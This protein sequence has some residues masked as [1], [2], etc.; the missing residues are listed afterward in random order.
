MKK[1]IIYDDD[2]EPFINSEDEC[3]NSESIQSGGETDDDND[4][5]DD[6]EHLDLDSDEEKGYDSEGDEEYDP[7]NDETLVDD[8]APKSDNENDDYDEEVD[9]DSENDNDNNDDDYIDNDEDNEPLSKTCHA[10]NLN[11]EFIT[12]DEDDSNMYAKIDFIQIKNEDRITDPQMTYYE[13]VRIL[14][15]RAQQINYG[16]IPLVKGVENLTSPQK[17]YIELVSK[18]TPMR[19]RRH[20][21]GKKYEDWSVS[22][23]ELYHVVNDNLFVPPNFDIEKFKK[24]NKIL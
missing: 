5:I 19:I 14:G 22:E 1:K 23:L 2:D 18:M 16:A 8:D 24:D 6:N 20:L 9:E 15:V 17:A 12:L 4:Q 3:S 11:K 13:M 21:P 10:T 7:V